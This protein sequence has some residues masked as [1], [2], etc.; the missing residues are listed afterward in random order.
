MHSLR[1]SQIFDPVTIPAMERNTEP[2]PFTGGNMPLLTWYKMYSVNDD[3]LDEQHK[4]LFGIFNKLYDSCVKKEIGSAFDNLVDELIS[5]AGYHFSTEERYMEEAGYEDIERHRQEHLSFS[6]RTMQLKHTDE[7]DKDDLAK[8][9]I[10]Y[11]GNWILHHVIEEDRKLLI[12][13]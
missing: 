5:Y 7:S 1:P 6:Q 11:L 8:E 10:V 13:R 3:V 4:T 12:A 2:I 9:L